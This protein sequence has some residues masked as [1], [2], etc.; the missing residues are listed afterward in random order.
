M[1]LPRLHVVTDDQVLAMD[2]FPTTAR[3]LLS[4]FGSRIALHLRGHGTGGGRLLSLIRSLAPEAER[5]GAALLVADRVDIALCTTV[6][7]VRLG[8]HSIPVASV[9]S[10]LPR[11]LLGYSAHGEVEAQEAT[12]AGAD[13]V[14]LGTIWATAS[15]P[16]REPAGLEL[17]ERTL[18]AVDVPVIVIGGATPVRAAEAVARGAHGAAVLR[19]VWHADDPVAAAAAYLEAL[20]ALQ[21]VTGPVG[22]TMQAGRQT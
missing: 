12:S 13:F 21:E 16:G 8:R 10:L 6:A 22:A 14:V 4:R 9:R 19:G 20:G 2:S 18:A 1:T 3:T 7:G 17:V 5:S 11:R 15:H